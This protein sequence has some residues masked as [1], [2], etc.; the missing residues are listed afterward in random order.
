MTASEASGLGDA[1]GGR[2]QT[3]PLVRAH[4][5]ATELLQSRSN[6]SVSTDITIG[7]TGVDP[8]TNHPL[9]NRRPDRPVGRLLLQTLGELGEP[10]CRL[11]TPLLG[12]LIETF[13]VAVHPSKHVTLLDV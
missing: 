3:A 8:P 11:P 4:D 7:S 5:H 1:N 12:E 2:I 13:V 10:F 9:D 6:R